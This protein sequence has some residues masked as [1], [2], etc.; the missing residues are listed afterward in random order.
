[1]SGAAALIYEI[2]WAR[3]IGLLFGHTVQASSIVLT[4]YFAGLAIG[5]WIGARCSARI[6]PLS[7]YAIAEVVIA[8]WAILIPFLIGVSESPTF[9][10]L[11]SSTSIVWQ[12]TFRGLFCFVL[13]LPA[14]IAMGA[15]LPFIADYFSERNH[16]NST[17]SSGASPIT[18]AYAINTA[19]ALA[20]TFAAT[21]FL[22]ITLGVRNSSYLA[23][24][25]SLGC[26]WLTARTQKQQE[27]LVYDHKAETKLT[28]GEEVRAIQ[29]VPNKSKRSP[30]NTGLF[31]LSA[32]SG[33]VT[34]AL[35]VL[36]NRMFSL[37][38]HNST[39]TF[40]IVIA[41][42]LAAL[43]LGAAIL[44]RLQRRYNARKLAGFASGFGGLATVSSV[45]VFNWMTD[46]TY[47]S[48]GSS[49]FT[50]MVGA[51][52]LVTVVVAPAIT[53]FGMILPLTWQMAAGSKNAG[54]AVGKLTAVNTL[55]AA[56]GASSTSF[57]LLRWVGLWHSFVL[58]AVLFFIASFVLLWN[59]H[60][61]KTASTFGVLLGL[62]SVFAMA[63]PI[64]SQSN[65][66]KDGER[67]V[68]RWNSAYGWIDVVKIEKQGA[69]KIRQNLHYRFGRTGGDGRE[70]RQAHIP[71]L[72]H[73]DPQN[74][75]FMGLGTGLTAGGAVPHSQVKKIVAVELIPEVVDAV[76][77][78]SQFNNNVVDHPKVKIAIDDARHYLLAH[79]EKYDVIVSDLFVPW[80]SKSGYLY[81]VENYQVAAERLNPDGLFCQWL[82]LYQLGPDEFESIANSFASVFPETTVWKSQPDM[83]WPV[84]ALIGSTQPIQADSN[85]IANRLQLLNQQTNRIDLTISSPKRLWNLYMGDWQLQ[86]NATFNTDEHPRV[87]FLTPISNRN[88]GL[89]RGK[90]LD[91][92]LN[93]I[94][95]NLPKN[96]AELE[97]RSTH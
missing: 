93:R 57:L 9:S 20:G 91:E 5:N 45:I 40:G 61:R 54:Q 44:S 86:S 71:L 32:L 33:F 39:Y 30:L 53:C 19:G 62:I 37:V 29:D 52:L 80:E 56:L 8:I 36:Y 73:N 74:V 4:S 49:F 77:T 22:L 69:Y 34:L 13:L 85:Q 64:E 1:M 24:V 78:L 67:L 7:G 28:L 46:L 51:I 81:T 60:C 88:H 21:F 87:E 42:F 63:S 76:R 38:F 94:L 41:V 59:E 12:T 90:I 79:E 89:L 16:V 23:A 83:T 66:K 55:A 26:A 96:S 48:F 84:I 75:L 50:Y 17:S 31:A 72:L 97:D 35:Q 58:V 27:R 70:F 14:T 3:Q 68:Q 92:Y 43:T 18:M 11:L 82:P 25:I 15:T 6:R 95:L 10:P 65:Q 47:F 2:S